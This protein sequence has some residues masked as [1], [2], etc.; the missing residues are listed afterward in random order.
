MSDYSIGQLANL[1]ECSAQIIRHYEQIGLLP[2]PPRSNGNQRRYDTDHLQRLQFI[3][4]SRDLGFSLE[5]IRQIVDLTDNPHQSC[6]AVD[7]IAQQHLEDVERR[8]AQLQALRSEL[9]RMIKDCGHGRVAACRVIETL[10][11]FSHEHCLESNHKS[12]ASSSS[13]KALSL[14][15]S[16]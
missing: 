8:I 7:S 4:H 5:Q 15:V 6:E 9:K 1:S 10:A 14:S 2:E 3:R 16:A 11:D 12:A 13:E